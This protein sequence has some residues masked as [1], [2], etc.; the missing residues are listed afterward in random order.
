MGLF[1]SINGWS[2]NVV[3]LLK[4]NPAKSIVL[5]DGYDLR[6][7]LDGRIDLRDFLVAKVAK[8]NLGTTPFLGA[9]MYL[10]EQSRS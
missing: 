7:V 1:L 4:Q 8:L 6:T 5:M 2:E 3:P 9:T 10:E